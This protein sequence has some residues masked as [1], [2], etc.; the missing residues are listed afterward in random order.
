MGLE[1]ATM[2]DPSTEASRLIRGATAR[3]RGR[4][5]ACL[6]GHRFAHVAFLSR[7]K[8]LPQRGAEK[9]V[10]LLAYFEVL[11]I[12]ATKDALERT[13]TKEYYSSLSLVWNETSRAS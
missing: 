3:S 7:E 2:Q 10:L 13:A 5:L 4:R 6:E 1:A 11:S 9:I 12:E 8:F